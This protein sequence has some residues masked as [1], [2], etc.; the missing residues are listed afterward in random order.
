MTPETNNTGT[1][2]SGPTSSG[3]QFLS[4]CLL[5][6]EI[7]E[8]PAVKV[9]VSR[10]G[11]W[12]MASTAKSKAQMLATALDSVGAKYKSDYFYAAGYNR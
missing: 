1:K 6:V 2:V 11:G 10:F 3:L 9:Y 12:M 4:F 7:V 5:Q 8:M